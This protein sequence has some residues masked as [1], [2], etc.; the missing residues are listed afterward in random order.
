M[1]QKKKKKKRE[2]IWKDILGHL[3]VL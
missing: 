3:F 2:R 1:L